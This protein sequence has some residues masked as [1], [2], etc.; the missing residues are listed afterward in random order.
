MVIVF[1]DMLSFACA[2]G[3]RGGLGPGDVLCRGQN[4]W[5]IP[6]KIVR[7]KLA[8]WDPEEQDLQW[9]PNRLSACESSFGSIF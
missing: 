4:F 1:T 2:D 6:G 7:T 9:I 5:F 3:S 8:L